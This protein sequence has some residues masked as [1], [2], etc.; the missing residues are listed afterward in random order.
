[1]LDSLLI[2]NFRLFQRLE[3]EGFGRINLI[4]GRNNSGKSAL[5]EA[6]RLYAT[7][8]DLEVLLSLVTSRQELHAGQPWNLPGNGMRHVFRHL[9][10]GHRLPAL[11]EEGIRL[12]PVRDTK[13]QISIKTSTS[14]PEG[15]F[16]DIG[17]LGLFLVVQRASSANTL[18]NLRD[19]LNDSRRRHRAMRELKEAP[20][21]TQSVP[22]QGIGSD[23]LASWWDRT[24]LT[25]LEDEVIAGLQLI[26]PRIRG[27]A[28]IEGEEGTRSRRIPMVKIAGMQEPLSLKSMGDGILRLFQIVLALVN[29]QDG[30]LLIDEVENGLHWSI[31][32]KV[33]DAVFRLAEKLNIQVFA[34][35]HSRDGIEAFETVWKKTQQAG[36]FYRL[37]LRDDGVVATPYDCETLSDALETDVEIR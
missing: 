34:T 6:V 21:P 7:D 25:D 9:F 33:W 30:I 24:S 16:E 28:F 11:T 20:C 18:L 26:E 12:G 17:D 29:A 8:A 23:E 27:L 2:R 37:D 14:P 36:A 3:L 5:L 15:R 32:P 19:D 31:Q 35:T 1:M 22:A 4:V 10:Y 13:A